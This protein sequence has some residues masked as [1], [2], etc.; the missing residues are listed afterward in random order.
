VERGVGNNP[1]AL[2]DMP[3]T[4]AA[5]WKYN[6]PRFVTFGFQ[7]RKHVIECHTDDARNILTNNPAGLDERN[8]AA[9]LRPEVTVILRASSHPGVT[10]R[11]AGESS[12]HNVNCR[13]MGEGADVAIAGNLRPVFRKHADTE[14]VIFHETRDRKARTFESE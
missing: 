14:R 3:R 11:L 5:S 2:P 9:H 1:D 10:E 12:D 7:V 4:E 13:G 8:N 6:R